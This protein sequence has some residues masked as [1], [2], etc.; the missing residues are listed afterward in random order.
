[1]T[2]S[3]LLLDVV[4]VLVLLLYAIGG[5]RRGLFATVVGMVGLLVGVGLCLWL[6]PG[7]LESMVPDRFGV[8][9]PVLLVACLFLVGA[10]SQVLALRL[11]RPL[12]RSLHR[13]RA[14]PLDSL[15]GAV[16][17]V[18]VAALLIWFA[19]G[20]LRSASSTTLGAALGRSR[21]VTAID[22]LIPSTSDRI[23]GRVVVALD[24]AGFPRVFDQL[25]AEPIEPVDP[26][27]PVT[28]RAPAVAAAARSVLRIDALAVACGRSQEGTGFVSQQG[29]VVT[30]AHVVAG[31]ERVSVRSGN[32]R[33]SA[34]VVAFDP[35]RDLAVLSVPDL[36]APPLR[37]GGRLA[38]GEQAVVAGYPLAGPYRVDAARVRGI[39]HA[40]GDD[41]YGKGRVTREVY[42]LRVTIQPGN[43]GGPLL[44]RGGA[45][46]GVIFARSLDD[47][48]TAY[49]LTLGEL[50]PVLQSV[51]SARVS[52]GT[53]SCTK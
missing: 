39:L 29:L 6:L 44:D 41:I 30:N 7:Q 5:Y 26:A 11:V 3:P 19:A 35:Q 1:M 4:L 47:A 46:V 16:V 33:L 12:H 52:V 18:T 13:S 15:L 42:S 22:S 40:N 2:V 23:L 51:S 36:T 49:A 50:R 32:R 37:E 17:T 10:L 9:R 24:S 27:D 48:G 34:A 20:V 43:S 8:L 45:V 28:A 14:R 25:T 31:S 38:T 21:V 53:G